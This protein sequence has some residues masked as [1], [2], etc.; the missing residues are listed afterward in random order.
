[1]DK[2]ELVDKVDIKKIVEVIMSEIVWHRKK[3]ANNL[4]ASKAY[5]DGFIAGLYQ[6]KWVILQMQVG[7]EE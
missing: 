7:E 2:Q 1:M 5:R 6:A 3:E 4:V